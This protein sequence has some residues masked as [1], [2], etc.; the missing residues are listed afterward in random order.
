LTRLVS[1]SDYRHVL[2]TT[3]HGSAA[4]G[5]TARGVAALRLPGDAAAAERSI[6]RLLPESRTA[7][8]SP[9]IAGVVDAVRRYFAGEAASF[10]EVVLDLQPQGEFLARIYAHVRALGW[11]QTTTYGAVAGA[12]GMGPKAAR[13]VGQAMARNPVPL[14]I[15]CHRVLAAGGASGGFSAPGGATAKRRMLAI[16]GVVLA[17]PPVQQVLPF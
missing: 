6:M 7:T 9:E 1:K 3:A 12:L 16:E 15:P 8:P 11:G 17:E 13:A 2:F 4:I 10:A 5:W 14:I